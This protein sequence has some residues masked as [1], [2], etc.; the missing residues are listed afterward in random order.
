MSRVNGPIV[1][2]YGLQILDAHPNY[3]NFIAEHPTGQP[4]DAHIV[5]THIYS[6][7]A[8]ANQWIDAG[9]IVGPAGADGADATLP[10]NLGTTDSPVFDKITLNNNGNGINIAVGD[11]TYLGD[12]NKSNV[13]KV[14]GQQDATKG[15]LSF[16]SAADKQIGSDADGKLNVYT[17]IVPSANAT[18]YLGSSTYRWAGIYV[19][20]GTIHI[21]DT[22][23]GEDATLNV[24]NGI[25][26]V[27]GANQLQVGQLKFVDNKIQSTTPSI[28]IEIG[29]TTD[30]SNLK[31]NRNVQIA[32]GKKITFGN[33]T[34]AE[35]DASLAPYGKQTVCVKTTGG[36]N[37]MYWGSCAS[38]G[39]S[40]GTDYYILA[41]FTNT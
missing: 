26:T 36:K 21:T 38:N 33:G 23:T 7:N 18:F 4:G 35:V 19:G 41:T 40:G 17:D 25:L 37:D 5:G 9:Q 29:Q 11:D 20:P 28:P 6:W 1:N 30:T 34:R 3:N 12:M 15:Y 32:P 2:Q 39:I 22:V 14:K 16:G 13:L 31:L 10:Q 27:N 24:S 8:E